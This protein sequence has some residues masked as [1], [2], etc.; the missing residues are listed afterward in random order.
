MSGALPPRPR[1]RLAPLDNVLSTATHFAL[2]RYKEKGVMFAG[3]TPDER[4]QIP[5]C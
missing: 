3:E 5:L 1:E 2:R 4:G